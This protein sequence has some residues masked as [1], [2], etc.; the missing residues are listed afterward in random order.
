MKNYRILLVDDEPDIRHCMQALAKQSDLSFDQAANGEEGLRMMSIVDYDCI[1]SDIKMP[2]MSGIEM[3]KRMRQLGKVT[4]ILFISA[5]ANEEFA[6]SVSDY[7][8]V[9]LMHKLE[10]PKIKEHI[11]EAIKLADEIKAIHREGDSIGED[12]LSLVN[13]TQKF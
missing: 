9:K 1:V 5:Y 13:K 6:H 11:L 4:P 12:F 3:L 10:L 8:A 7:G 2:Q